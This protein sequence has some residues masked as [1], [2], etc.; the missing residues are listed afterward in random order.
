MLP[1]YLNALK[2]KTDEAMRELEKINHVVKQ[3]EKSDTPAEDLAAQ[4]DIVLENELQPIDPLHKTL[5][6]AKLEAKTHAKMK[7]IMIGNAI[8]RKIKGIVDNG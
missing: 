8:E 3:I 4:L 7:S 5:D 2:K 6:E 1:E